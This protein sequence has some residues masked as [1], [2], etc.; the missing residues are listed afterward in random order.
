MPVYLVIGI[1]NLIQ[2]YLSTITVIPF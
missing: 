1:D 2:I